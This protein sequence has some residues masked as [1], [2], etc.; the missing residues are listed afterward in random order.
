MNLNQAAHGDREFGFICSRLRQNRKVVV[1]HWEDPEV[2][3]RLDVWMRAACAW[4]DSQ[5]LKLARFGD[6]MR[7][8]AVTEGDKVAAQHRFGWA[9]NGYGV[10][11][12]AAPIARVADADVERLVKEYAA[13]EEG[14]FSAFTDTFEDLTGLEQEA[15]QGELDARLPARTAPICSAPSFSS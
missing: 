15:A 6:N 3:E 14:G 7:Q 5:K 11:D 4:A 2:H 8:V 13:L 12:L 10:G 1:G 9:V